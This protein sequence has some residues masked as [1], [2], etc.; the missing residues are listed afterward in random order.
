MLRP[1]G[2][3]ALIAAKFAVIREVIRRIA[4]VA[5]RGGTRRRSNGFSNRGKFR[6]NAQSAAEQPQS[7]S[8]GDARA[9][10]GGNGLGDGCG[11]LDG[12]SGTGPRRTTTD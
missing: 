7:A 12:T 5:R 8:G 2:A 10:S 9:R 11:K 3:A 1:L 6:A 4:R